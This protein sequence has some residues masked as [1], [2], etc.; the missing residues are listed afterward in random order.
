MWEC[1]GMTSKASLQQGRLSGTHPARRRCS[2]PCWPPSWRDA[3]SQGASAKQFQFNQLT[4]VEVYIPSYSC[5]YLQ[6]QI[7]IEY[8]K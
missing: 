1:T 8:N 6:D 4:E 7:T 3:L 2:W 5:T